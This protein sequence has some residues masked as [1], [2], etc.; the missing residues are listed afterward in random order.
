MS[1]NLQDSILAYLDGAA[2]DAAIRG[3]NE[4]LS[5]EPQA[6]RELLLA[7]ALETHLRQVLTTRHEVSR[8]TDVAPPPSAVHGRLATPP[9]AAEPHGFQ[10]ASRWR[11]RL[12]VAATLLVATAAGWLAFAHFYPGQ[13][14]PRQADA[15]TIQL[16]DMLGLV[17]ALTAGPDGKPR[18]VQ[19]YAGDRV[20]PGCKLWTCPWGGATVRFPD[21]ATVSLDRST[22]A[23]VVQDGDVRRVEVQQGIV[24]AKTDVPLSQSA[25]LVKT[26]HATAAVQGAQVTF[27]VGKDE[28][29]VEVATGAVEV[30]RTTD[31]E[32]VKVERNHTAVVKPGLTL[33]SSDGRFQWHLAPAQSQ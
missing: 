22:T 1:E 11:R 8:Q 32:K 6:C 28:T 13:V 23:R 16:I 2:D 14:G 27:V 33:K 3:L 26:P 25:L 4:R 15:A 30:T 18:G 12:A 20:P 10:H 7:A 24:C 31:Q 19:L 29:S 9:R 17:L 21:G 5:A